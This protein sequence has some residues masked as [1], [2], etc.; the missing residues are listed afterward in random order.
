MSTFKI[1]MAATALIYI[2]VL[3][4]CLFILELK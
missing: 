3:F 4:E 2:M 1:L